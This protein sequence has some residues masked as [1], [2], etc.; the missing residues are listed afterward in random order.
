MK[1]TRI[2]IA[3]NLTKPHLKKQ[4]SWMV[5][6]NNME[7]IVKTSLLVALFTIICLVM[8][9]FPVKKSLFSAATWIQDQGWLGYLCYVGVFC[10]EIVLGI[11]STLFETMA[12]FIFGFWAAIL[13]TTVGKTLGCT[14]A[15]LLGRSI[16]KDTLGAFLNKRFKIFKAMSKVLNNSGLKML[17]LCQ[18]AYLPI[19]VKCFGLSI[20]DVEL[21]PFVL[22]VFVCGIPYT[23]F[24]SYIG[25]ESKDLINMLSGESKEPVV[26][27]TEKIVFM[28]IALASGILAM[29]FMA[30]F[31]KK[32]MR[33]MDL[34]DS[35]LE[36]DSETSREDGSI[37]IQIEERTEE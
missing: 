2:E 20:M 32:Q 33:L 14:L 34:E 23:I 1:V 27:S 8:I 30:R 19:F 18:L 28:S 24:L 26:I 12:G 29:G 4:S 10:V 7:K 21:Q 25:S 36:T 31:A 13:V 22:S 11:P 16:G 5:F 6:T 35:E 17:F 37:D 15:F 3:T 9:F